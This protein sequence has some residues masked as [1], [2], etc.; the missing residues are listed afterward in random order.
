LIPEDLKTNQLVEVA[1]INHQEPT[2]YKT[3]VE[4]ITKDQ[5]YIG[6]P[7]VNGALLPVYQGEKVQV[8]YQVKKEYNQVITYSFT[9]LVHSREKSPVPVMVLGLPDKVHKAQRR[10]YLRIPVELL[11]NWRIPED[12]TFHKGIV[13]DLSGGGCLLKTQ[14]ELSEGSKIQLELTLPDK[15]TLVLN[16]QAVRVLNRDDKSNIVYHIGLEFEN[17]RENHRDVIV[18]YLFDLQRE[19]IKK[20]RI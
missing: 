19:S 3:R 16:A 15:P 5:I 14:Q 18:K 9:S 13:I 17:I 2:L 1:I 8:S 10:N 7:I 6:I 11:C 12:D 20:R 4:G